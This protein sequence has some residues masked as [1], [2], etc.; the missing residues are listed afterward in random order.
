VYPGLQCLAAVLCSIASLAAAATN[1][2][3]K[4]LAGGR[5]QIGQV[6][7]DPKAKTV[8]FPALVNMR[9]GLVEY[10]VVTTSGKVHESVFKTDAEPFHIHTA[11]LLLGAKVA[12]NVD[13]AIF[14][15]SKREIPGSKLKIEVFIPGPN[16]RTNLMD[17]FVQ[18]AQDKTPRAN[19]IPQIP[20]WIYNGSRTSDGVF[21]AQ[22]EGSIVSLIA[23]PAALINNPRQDRE[24]DELWSANTA[25]VPGVDTPVELRITL[26]DDKR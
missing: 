10:A 23:D 1:A 6:T 7:L 11:M 15:D 13:S 4:E 18:N 8:S 21:L 16:L 25:E 9:T 5:L 19:H 14:F 17:R 2:P 3:V 26:S 12:T 22:R 20:F 24:N